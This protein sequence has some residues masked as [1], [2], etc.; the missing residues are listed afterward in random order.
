MK[1]WAR[2]MFGLWVTQPNSFEMEQAYN[3]SLADQKPG[4]CVCMLFYNEKVD[5]SV[6]TPDVEDDDDDG[7]GGTGGSQA[8]QASQAQ[9]GDSVGQVCGE[10]NLVF[11]DDFDH[12]SCQFVFFFHRSHG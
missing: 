2:S 6:V 8:T 10:V 5:D 3:A 4:C 12:M 1:T 7:M 11:G 9:A